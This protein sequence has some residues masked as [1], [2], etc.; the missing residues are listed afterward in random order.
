MLFKKHISY[1][2]STFLFIGIVSIG[3]SIASPSFEE[4]SSLSLILIGTLISFLISIV[5]LFVQMYLQIKVM[6]T[7]LRAMREPEYTPHFND[8]FVREGNGKLLVKRFFIT[9]ILTGLFVLGGFILF[10][11]PGIY[12]AVR[13][14]FATY[15]VADTGSKPMDA[16]R[17]SWAMTKGRFWA[18]LRY[19]LIVAFFAL[20]TIIAFIVTAPLM[21]VMTMNLYERLR[22]AKEGTVPIP[23]RE[24]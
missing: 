16:I 21:Q 5:S 15:I 1:F 3:L 10:I 12:I 4:Y 17:E 2:I 6:R 22:K 7:T 24:V 18:L 11:L 23:V 9:S 20:I 8:F 13:M 14:S 19:S